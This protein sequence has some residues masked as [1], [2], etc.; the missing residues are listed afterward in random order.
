MLAKINLI[1]KAIDI[2][3]KQI[4]K[5]KVYWLDITLIKMSQKKN[6][7]RIPGLKILSR[8]IFQRCHINF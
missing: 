3:I 2:M 8:R 6:K 4:F 7:Q 5:R 1:F